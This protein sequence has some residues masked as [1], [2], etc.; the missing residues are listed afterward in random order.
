MKA[1]GFALLASL[2]LNLFI[3]GWWLSDAWRST[4]F[5]D[6]RPISFTD[7]AQRRLPPGA[8]D[9]IREPLARADNVIEAGFKARQEILERLRYLVPQEPYDR[10]AVEALLA[11]LPGQRLANEQTQWKLVG[12]ALA[13]L[14]ADQRKAFAELMFAPRIQFP[15]SPGWLF[16]Q[17]R[18]W[19]N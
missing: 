19:T 13:K 2:G 15:P 12:E 11:E 6:P 18:G 10:Q 1:I 14:P 8:L 7:L 3:A 17:R 4:R 9:L 5:V 16:P